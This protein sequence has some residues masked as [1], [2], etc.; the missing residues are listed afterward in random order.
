[1]RTPFDAAVDNTG[2]KMTD[3][4]HAVGRLDRRGE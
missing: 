3:C 4:C 1:M 2:H